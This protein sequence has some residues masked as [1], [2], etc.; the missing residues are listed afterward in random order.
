[1]FVFLTTRHQFLNTAKEQVE[2]LEGMYKKMTTLFQN[3]AKY[4]AFNPKKYTMEEFFT[5]LRDFVESFNVC[6]TYFVFV[7]PILDNP[8]LAVLV[9]LNS[10]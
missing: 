1:M 3:T 5:D 2:V 9:A 6:V 4:F 10:R 7:Y 8:H